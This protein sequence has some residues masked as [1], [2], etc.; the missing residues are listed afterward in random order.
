MQSSES[1]A[2]TPISAR[3]IPLGYLRSFLTLLVVT[4]HALL[5][6]HPYAPPPGASLAAEPRLWL[7]FP[8]VDP[9]RIN[10]VEYLVGFNDAFFMSLMFLISGAFAWGSMHRRG[11]L[12]FAWERLL[13]LGIPFLFAVILLAPLAYYPT[14][15]QMGSAGGSFMDQ[16]RALGEMPA[17]PAWFLWVL[18]VCGLVALALVK[19]FPGACQRAGAWARWLG[20][21]PVLFALALVGL[22]VLS[23][24]PM[25]QIYGSQTWLDFGPFYLQI[26]R[27][28]HYLMY[29][30]VGTAMGA[31]GL[32]A[33]LFQPDGR[34]A[35]RWP[36]WVLACLFFFAAGIA[37]L[38]LTFKS[39]AT[40][41]P[42][43]GL[44]LLGHFSFVLT[45][46]IT[47]M[48]FIA[49][50]VRFSRRPVRF[51]D[52]LSS[53]AYGI[54]V[55]HYAA[56]SWLQWWLLSLPIS[57]AMKALV[58]ISGAVA[59]TWIATSLLRKIPGVSRIL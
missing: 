58:V 57:A 48:A 15:L 19:I 55:F 49:L 34:L 21:R 23:Y 53:N 8:V 32:Q 11:A 24:M 56:V 46:A 50:F 18:F 37:V 43:L 22:S 38:L 29:F 25:A 13:R 12:S 20:E 33:G 41:G 45:C 5:A 59:L 35:S 51:L 39:Y 1:D 6:Y 42:S 27:A 2:A 4:H 47:C 40:G 10:G 36:M 17:G 7:A 28:L 3:D 14:W 16:W 44:Q 54:Y 26:G 52:H 9:S 30:L 31:A